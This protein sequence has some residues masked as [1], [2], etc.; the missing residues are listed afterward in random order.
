MS[1]NSEISS[2]KRG[3]DA[4]HRASNLDTH[5]THGCMAAFPPVFASAMSVRGKGAI[6]RIR[7]IPPFFESARR[8]LAGGAA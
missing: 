7:T 2:Q 8:T 6:A 3:C 4:T 1:D 5:L